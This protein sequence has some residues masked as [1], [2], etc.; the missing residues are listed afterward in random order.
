MKEFFKDARYALKY[1]EFHFAFGWGG[2]PGVYATYYDGYI[3]TFN[4][5]FCYFGWWN[6]GFD[7][8]CQI[9]KVTKR[10][11]KNESLYRISQT[12]KKLLREGYE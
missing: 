10:P 8:P 6:T 7:C 4:L 1:E 2:T 5:L 11:Q 9:C 3:L 12:L